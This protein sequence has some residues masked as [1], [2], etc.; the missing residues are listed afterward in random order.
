MYV[1][2]GRKFKISTAALIV[3]VSLFF[4]VSREVILSALCAITVHETGHLAMGKLRGAKVRC[5]TV[6][7]LGASIEF[8][9]VFCSLDG[10]AVFGAGIFFNLLT[11]S[12]AGLFGERY[13]AFILF[14]VGYALLNALPIAGLDGGGIFSSATA[15]FLP[16]RVHGAVCKTVSFVFLF[17]LWQC[18]IY[19]LFKT[20]ANASPFLMCMFLFFELFCRM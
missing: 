14:S 12:F 19:V 5:L 2:V 6:G 18:G 8:D 17:I 15:F 9:R 10:I 11:A 4:T 3:A 20:E 7:G 13:I 16:F 1:Y